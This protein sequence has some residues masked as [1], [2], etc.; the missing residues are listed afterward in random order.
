MP[1]SLRG[2]NAT[3]AVNG[4]FRQVFA[5]KP[6]LF[7]KI[8]RVRI[9]EVAVGEPRQ[10][11]RPAMRVQKPGSGG[12]GDDGAVGSHGHCPKPGILRE[13]LKA[14]LRDRA[15]D[16]VILAAGDNRLD[17][18]NAARPEFWWGNR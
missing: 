3:K 17:A 7:T 6:A 2:C 5:P 13:R 8:L 9:L 1:K 18:D 15:Q 12:P 11:D 4:R 10:R 16:L 14:R